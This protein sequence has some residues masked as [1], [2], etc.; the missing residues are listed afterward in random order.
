MNLQ[1]PCSLLIIVSLSLNEV[2][3]AQQNSSAHASTD[4]QDSYHPGITFIVGILSVMLSIVFLVL[5]YAKF[6]YGSYS[7]MNGI[8]P[9]HGADAQGGVRIDSSSRFSGIDRKA[10]ELLPLFRF[11]SVGGSREG[12]ECVVC[13]N[14]FEDSE[15]L[16]LLPKC[17]HAFHASCID[18]WLES[19]STCPLCRYR[20][21]PKD[22]ASFRYS[23]S[24]RA[25]RNPSGLSS[26]DIEVGIYVERE[27]DLDRRKD[28]SL[29]GDE[30][31]GKVPSFH[32]FRHR[33]MVSELIDRSRWS[34]VNSSDLLFL[35]SEMIGSISSRRL[36]SK[37]HDN[38]LKIKEDIK[39]KRFFES[40]KLVDRAKDVN[41][42]SSSTC[43]ENN[44]NTWA[45]LATKKRCMSEI[46]GVPR[47]A[48]RS[49]DRE[50]VAVD[51]THDKDMWSVI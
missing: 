37:Q 39:R 18:K 12:L 21:D 16:R 33:I 26:E 36:T 17:K 13:I 48:F 29:L 15:T 28:T 24:A 11:E 43:G 27:E 20:V 44:P 1:S 10:I 9:R 47:F 4:H 45:N 19:H 50:L 2:V 22:I 46:S 49:K 23:T 41:V 31:G 3:L 51:R 42:P 14:R 5:A 25:L 8:A 6:C 34:D 35:Q 38:V 40:I 7:Y 30:R 32:K